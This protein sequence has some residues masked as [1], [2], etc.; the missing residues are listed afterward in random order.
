M[1]EKPLAHNF[2]AIFDLLKI[3][4]ENVICQ[5]FIYPNIWAWEKFY[6]NIKNKWL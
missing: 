6:S 3:E 1:L 4:I 2:T 5:N